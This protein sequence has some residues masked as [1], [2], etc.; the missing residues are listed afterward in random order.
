MECANRLKEELNLNNKPAPPANN[1]KINNVV[2]N[3]SSNPPVPP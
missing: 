3:A 2:I 1:N